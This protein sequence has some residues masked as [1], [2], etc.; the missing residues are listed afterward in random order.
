MHEEV[1]KCADIGDIKGLRYIFLDCLDVDPTFEKYKEDFEYC[2]NI[3]GLFEKHMELT[4]ISDDQADWTDNYWVTLKMDLLKNFSLKRFQHMIVVAKVI[5]AEKIER[6]LK[7]RAQQNQESKQSDRQIRRTQQSQ[8]SQSTNFVKPFK[9][10]EQQDREI[11]EEKRKLKA[12]NQRIEKE[13]AAHNAQPESGKEKAAQQNTRETE[14]K[15]AMG[16]VVA[17]LIILLVVIVVIKL[18]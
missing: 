3:P 5:Y 1:K 7:E 4:P 13:Q 17:I 11:E 14:I 12:Y 8:H 2:K 9:T 10:K 18:K 6:I 15:K 16:A